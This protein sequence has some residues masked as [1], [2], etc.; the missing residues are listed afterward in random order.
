[1]DFD[2]DPG[3]DSIDETVELDPNVR[4]GAAALG[5]EDVG[6]ERHDA[7]LLASRRC[8]RAI[9]SSSAWTSLPPRTTSSPPT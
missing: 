7:N 5:V 4:G 3:D 6:R 2:V 8:S 9:S 1:M